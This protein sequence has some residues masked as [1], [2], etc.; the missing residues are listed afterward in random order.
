[1]SRIPTLKQAR[2]DKKLMRMAQEIT[3]PD[4]FAEHVLGMK[5]YPKQK[6]ALRALEPEDAK[7]SFTSCNEGGKTRMVVCAFVLWHM[8]MFP[9]GVVDATSGSYRQ[10]E[11]QLMPALRSYKDKFPNWMFSA[12]PH[13]RTEEYQKPGV[14]GG[15]FRGFST[16]QEGRAEGDHSDGPE[17]PLAYVVDEAKSCQQWLRGVVEGRVRP[18]RLLLT[19][20]HGFAEGWL[21]ESQTNDKKFYTCVNQS[22]EDCP[23][24]KPEVIAEVR[25]KWPGPFGDSILGYGFIPLVEDAIFGFREVDWCMNTTTLLPKFGDVHAFCDFAW[26]NDGDES[27]LAV[28]NGNVVKLEACF[29]ADSLHAVCDRFVAEYMRVGLLPNQ[30]S[31]DNGG[32]GSLVMDELDR[33][34]WR[35]NRVDNGDAA[36]D[37]E[38]YCNMGT[39]I[40]YEASKLING[41]QI[42]L[43]NDR[44]LRFQL[45]NRKRVPGLKGKLKMESKQDMKTRGVMS[46]D[47][48]DAILGCMSRVGAGFFTSGRGGISKITAAAVGSYKSIGG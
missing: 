18:T 28:R 41:K 6:E 27:V 39:E 37:D 29:R 12:E 34:G 20:S 45:L 43:P 47:R 33:R 2:K 16:D 46:P 9:K 4:G 26:S 14:K 40:W 24:I 17:A 30:I 21:Y 19:S 25:A 32:G 3:R 8:T 22:A 11:D 13:I 35:L 1:M 7:V 48:A 42:I 23:H 36:N 44:D 15:F 31:G 5:L 10:L 38:H